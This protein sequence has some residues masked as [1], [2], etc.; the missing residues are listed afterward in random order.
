MWKVGQ[1][2]LIFHLHYL[3]CCKKGHHSSESLR[4]DHWDRYW[5]LLALN[6]I[7]CVLMALTE[8][9]I[10]PSYLYF[11]L[12]S[13]LFLILTFPISQIYLHGFMRIFYHRDLQ[14]QNHL[15]SLACL[16][17]SK[18]QICQ[19]NS[20]PLSVLLI[21]DWTQGG[22]GW[23][24]FQRNLK[25]SSL[26]HYSL[27][28][29]KAEEKCFAEICLSNFALASFFEILF[30]DLPRL[31]WQFGRLSQSSQYFWLHGLRSFIFLGRMSQTKKAD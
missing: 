3:V 31:F 22:F 16:C 26:S 4:E 14:G 7:I 19:L 12:L 8:T 1:Q 30:Q 23:T 17:C 2:F 18:S 15:S 21:Y 24:S 10:V 9:S 20:V 28:S 27:L 11:P 6:T 13:S 25:W 5:S 29:F